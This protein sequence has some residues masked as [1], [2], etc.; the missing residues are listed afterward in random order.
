MKEW[1]NQ[2]REEIENKVS[3]LQFQQSKDQNNDSDIKDDLL[4]FQQYKEFLKDSGL[5]VNSDTYRKKVNLVTMRENRVRQA[6]G[7]PEKRLLVLDSELEL[8]IE[9]LDQETID[10]WL[11]IQPSRLKNGYRDRI[12][13]I[14]QARE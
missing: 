11:E 5:D 10:E 6:L 4:K 12:Q 2:R 1:F 9:T 7:L 14:I 8:L 13:D 3:S